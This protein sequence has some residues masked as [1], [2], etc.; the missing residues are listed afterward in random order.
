MKK[1]LLVDD[2][3]GIA[4]VVKIILTDDGYAVR[5][6]STGYSV[7][8]VVKEYDPNLI[9]LDIGLPG[10]S[11]T[12]ICKELKE[13]SDVPPILFFSAHA[14]EEASIALCKADGFIQ[15]PFDVKNLLKEVRSHIN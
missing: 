1:V 6:H 3:P 2:D 9:L 14:R 10:K 5:I 8:E 4:E 11:G 12:T 15:K 7:P 13:I